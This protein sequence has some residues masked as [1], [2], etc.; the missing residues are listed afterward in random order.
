MILE[1]AD[2]LLDERN[3]ATLENAMVILCRTAEKRSKERPNRYTSK[4]GRS[5]L[6]GSFL[7]LHNV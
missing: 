2:P 6:L 1:T 4:E 5:L 7:N 3:D